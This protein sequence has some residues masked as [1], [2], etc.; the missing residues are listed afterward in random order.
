MIE[1]IFDPREP[2]DRRPR[3]GMSLYPNQKDLRA[4]NELLS[5]W[6]ISKTEEIKAKIM[7]PEIRGLS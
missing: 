7:S 5:G 6:S 2:T 3:E 4:V 1:G